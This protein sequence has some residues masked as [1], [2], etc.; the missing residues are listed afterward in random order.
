[1]HS[2]SGR[3]STRSVFFAQI[4]VN[5]FLPADELCTQIEE[6]IEDAAGKGDDFV[7]CQCEIVVENTAIVI[8]KGE[9]TAS[10]ILNPVDLCPS[11]EICAESA[12]FFAAVSVSIRDRVNLKQLR[13]D[14]TPVG[15]P[16]ITVTGSADISLNPPS[17][18]LKSCSVMVEGEDGKCTCTTDGCKT[19]EVSYD[20]SSINYEGTQGP[21]S[22]GCVSM[23]TV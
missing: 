8:P 4:I 7:A 6:F 18:D 20:C 3:K 10:C 23:A 13:A 5:R 14:I 9:G 1:M 22:D 15:F 12:S 11:P 16:K 19:G 2:L 21:K 17:I